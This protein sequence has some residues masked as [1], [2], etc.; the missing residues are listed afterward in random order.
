MCS[1]GA[2]RCGVYTAASYVVDKM[3]HDDE[4]DVLL[5]C[6]YVIAGRPTAITSLVGVQCCYE[7]TME[8]LKDILIFRLQC[9]TVN[10]SYSYTT[11]T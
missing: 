7:F 2:S 6:R 9:Q 10:K 1:D 8:W 4:V 3:Q 11:W 5:S